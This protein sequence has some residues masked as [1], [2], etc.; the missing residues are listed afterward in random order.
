MKSRLLHSRILVCLIVFNALVGGV[1]GATL[2]SPDN[3]SASTTTHSPNVIFQ[4]GTVANA[5]IYTNSTSASATTPTA[6]FPTTLNTVTGTHTSGSVPGSVNAID[7]NY[8]ITASTTSGNPKTAETEYI[9]PVS[10]ATPLQL[11]FTIVEQYDLGSIPVT[12][13]VFNYTANT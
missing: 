11:N 1:T 9:F 4:K 5:T 13:Q 2:Q 7:S 3:A 6:Y 12:I 8:V 10:T